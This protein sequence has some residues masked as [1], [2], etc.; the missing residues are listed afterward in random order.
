MVGGILYWSL[1]I[2]MHGAADQRTD[3][4]TKRG[5]ESRSTRLKTETQT[6]MKKI[7]EMQSG[8]KFIFM[9]EDCFVMRIWR[10][11]KVETRGR[12]LT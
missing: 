3:G 6:K 5:V 4:S 8:G 7:S 12:S 10:S 2:L 9:K 1:V 11:V